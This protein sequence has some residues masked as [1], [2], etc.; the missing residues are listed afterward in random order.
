MYEIQN[1]SEAS[2]DNLVRVHPDRV[3][4][5]IV[6]KPYILLYVLSFF[7]SSSRFKEGT[8]RLNVQP[9]S[10]INIICPHIGT[11]LLTT[12]DSNSY[13]HYENFWSVD[14]SS[15]HSCNVNT[16]I[17]DNKI[18]FKCDKP[19]LLNFGQLVFQSH[20]M[21][22]SAVY[23]KGKTYFFICKYLSFVDLK[24]GYCKF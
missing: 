9:L 18:R 14:E 3:L 15:Y 22:N 12:D 1:P 23:K 2:L 16:S 19:L 7:F 8:F 13:S 24:L 11:S 21:D 6:F 10:K 4:V 5:V 20:G 17:A